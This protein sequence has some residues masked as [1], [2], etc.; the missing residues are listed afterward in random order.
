VS[1]MTLDENIA[2]MERV[3]LSRVALSRVALAAAR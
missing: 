1:V 2:T 3:A